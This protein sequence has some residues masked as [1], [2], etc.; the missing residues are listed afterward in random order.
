MEH[1]RLQVRSMAL[2]PTIDNPQK[3]DLSH[4]CVLPVSVLE[5]IDNA[6][7]IDNTPFCF[8]ID[9]EL[10]VR[11]IYVSVLE[12]TAEEGFIHLP[13]ILMDNCFVED[14]EAVTIQYIEAPKGSEII[15]QPENDS[16]YDIENNKELLENW[17]SQNYKIL[18][19]GD[20]IG[21]QYN[22][23]D[24]FMEITHLEPCDVILAHDTEMVLDY[25]KSIKEESKEFKIK[26]EEEKIQKE[27]E[28]KRNELER[29][30]REIKEKEEEKIIEE[31]SFLAQLH[32]ERMVRKNLNNN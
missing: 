16:F 27:E 26:R 12:F 11:D 10:M 22:N 30:E 9:T 7:L 32:R 3:Y 6:N 31:N 19:L 1:F 18:Q 5:K 8:K 13:K 15:L 29:I 2:H 28:E 21:F 20:R 17:I 25:R 14:Y 23:E 24:I 4:F